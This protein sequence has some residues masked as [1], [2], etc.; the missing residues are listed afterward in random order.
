MK[1]E[2]AG[3]ADAVTMQNSGK[4]CGYHFDREWEAIVHRIVATETVS[5]HFCRIFHF[6]VAINVHAFAPQLFNVFLR[7]LLYRILRSPS[8]QY[9]AQAIVFVKCFIDR[10]LRY[11]FFF[12]ASTLFSI[13]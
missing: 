6:L 2:D 8:F 5:K 13:S 3:V 4:T 12:Y 11:D 7:F 9:F 10:C 1:N